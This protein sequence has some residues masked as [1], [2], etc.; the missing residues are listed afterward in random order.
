MSL[1]GNEIS[2]IV[3][4]PV[5]N[6]PSPSF[7]KTID[8][9]KK[10]NTILIIDEISSGFRLLTGGAHLKYG[11]KPDVAVFSKGLGN[12]FSDLSYFR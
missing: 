3:M 1:H 4:E 6:K 7:F 12:G 11:I 8:K 10:H 9:Y 5:R 2:A